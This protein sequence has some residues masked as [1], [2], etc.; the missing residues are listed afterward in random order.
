[1][2]SK[3]KRILTNIYWDIDLKELWW[4]FWH[5]LV[6]RSVLGRYWTRKALIMKSKRQLVWSNIWFATHITCIYYFVTESTIIKKTIF[7]D[8]QLMNTIYQ[9]VT[10]WRS[11]EISAFLVKIVG[12]N[13]IFLSLRRNRTTHITIC[14]KYRFF[15]LLY[16]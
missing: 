6:G 3:D 13:D 4:R 2:W 9:N 8:L 7:T 10:I 5:I 16:V 1:M 14:K 12:R 11:R 15:I